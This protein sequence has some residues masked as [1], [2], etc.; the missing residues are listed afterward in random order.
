MLYKDHGSKD[1][2]ISLIGFNS[3][4]SDLLAFSQERK[5]EFSV[6]HDK[7]HIILKHLAFSRTPAKILLSKNNEIL[8]ID[9]CTSD[10][11][12]YKEYLKKVESL[13]SNL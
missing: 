8:S 11:F 4:I 9:S 12:L 7:E 5:L 2:A 3:K 6:L 1:I 13:L 10:I